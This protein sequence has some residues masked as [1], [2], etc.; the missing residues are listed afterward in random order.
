MADNLKY[1]EPGSG[2]LVATDDVGSVHYQIMK[3]DIGKPDGSSVPIVGQI[4]VVI[5]SGTVIVT[6]TNFDIRDLSDAQDSVRAVVSGTVQ[7]FTGHNLPV[8]YFPLLIAG[9]SELS[10]DTAP[11][12]LVDADGDITRIAVS[13]DGSVY[14]KPHPPR[15][16]HYAQEFTIQMTDYNIHSGVSNL[17]HYICSIYWA[18][19]GALNLIIKDGVAVTS[20]Q[21]FKYY[22]G[23]QGDGVAMTFNPPMKMTANTHI[24]VTTSAGVN[25]FLSITGYTA[26]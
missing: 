14:T 23:G 17:S 1:N 10:D 22:A 6:A 4:P 7:G 3:L 8:D 19:N 26:P 11:A 20:N 13:R 24:G 21:K 12:N 25:N 15:I 16:W 2:P 9:V 18:A 5:N